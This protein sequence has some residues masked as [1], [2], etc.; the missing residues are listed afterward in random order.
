MKKPS[1]QFS[2]QER[3]ALY[4]MYVQII[5]T[6]KKKFESFCNSVLKSNILKYDSIQG[7][8]YLSINKTFP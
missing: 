7:R 5:G 6:S 8:Y 3:K 2:K 4:G 1:K